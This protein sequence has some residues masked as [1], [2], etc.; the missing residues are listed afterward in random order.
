MPIWHIND[1]RKTMTKE[2][3]VVRYR[4][5]ELSPEAQAKAIENEQRVLAE[6]CPTEIIEEAMLD[7]LGEI[8]NGTGKKFKEAPASIGFSEWDVSYSQGRTVVLKGQINRTDA[9]QL[10]KVWPKKIAYVQFGNRSYKG[11]PIDYYD[12]EGED[13][14]PSAAFVQELKDIRSKLLDAGAAEYDA[15]QSE[16]NARDQ[17]SYRDDESGHIFLEDGTINIPKGLKETANV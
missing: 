2:F 11:Q 7:K 16:D 6:I 13:V 14:E 1:G 8:L 9:P 10:R 3:T 4:F 12:A 17:L 15:F 5:E